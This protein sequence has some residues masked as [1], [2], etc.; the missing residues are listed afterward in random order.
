MSRTLELLTFIFFALFVFASPFSIALSQIAFGISL[1]CFIALSFN[2]DV[3]PRLRPLNPVFRMIGI[4]LVWL[5]FS[6]YMS[7][8][9]VFSLSMLKEEW[10]FLIVPIGAYLCRDEKQCAILIRIFAISV[11]LIAAYGILQYFTHTH[12]LKPSAPDIIDG[13]RIRGNFS[14]P[15]TFANFFGTASLFLLGTALSGK[16]WI[17]N[18]IG[19]LLVAASILGIFAVVLSS[20]RTA[21]AAILVIL[22]VAALVAGKKYFLPIGIIV[23]GI[24]AAVILIPGSESRYLTQLPQDVNPGYEGGRPFIWKNS[25]DIIWDNPLFGVGTGN[26]YD[27]YVTRLK[28]DIYNAWKYSHAHND[29]LTVTVISGI[30]GGLL[31]IGVWLMVLRTLYRGLKRLPQNSAQRKWLIGS[32]LGCAFFLIASLTEATFQDEEVRQLLMFVWAVGLSVCLEEPK[33]EL[34]LS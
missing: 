1:F 32:L 2:G 16:E 4:Y 17:K 12:F 24:L 21:I 22:F 10:L 8:R 23:V 6:A 18:R 29:I 5:T 26:F 20:S 31:F 14:H 33:S 19:S 30:P 34:E 25:I 11:A 3:L 28:P 9:P 27:E 7:D 13:D 15:L